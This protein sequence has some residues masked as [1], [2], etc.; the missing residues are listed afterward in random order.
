MTPEEKAKELVESFAET[1]PA[2]ITYEDEHTVLQERNWPIA[3][4]CAL[5]A[6][7]EIQKVVP[8]V[9][10]RQAGTVSQEY[11]ASENQFLSYWYKVKDEIK[12]Q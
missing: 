9:N 7:E 5:I 6:V 4:E 2:I 3:K 8:F 11:R 1:I 12:K 10:K